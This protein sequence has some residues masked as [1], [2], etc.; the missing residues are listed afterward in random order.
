MNF[1]ALIAFLVANRQAIIDLIQL[2]KEIIA[3]FGRGTAV[4]LSEEQFS[5][6][7]AEKAQAYPELAALCETQNF[8]FRELLQ[9]ILENAEAIKEL[10]QVIADLFR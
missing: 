1:L 7:A 3:Q 9:L 4:A 2:V 8:N 6:L 5:T 10:I